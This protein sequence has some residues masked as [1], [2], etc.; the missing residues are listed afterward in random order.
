[1]LSLSGMSIDVRTRRNH[2]LFPKPTGGTPEADR[3]A[4]ML[5]SVWLGMRTRRGARIPICGAGGVET[6]EMLRVYLAGTGGLSV[7]QNL[8]DPMSAHRILAGALRSGGW[9]AGAYPIYTN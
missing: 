7:R 8:Y 4:T 1:M 5:P 6:G 9:N 3:F 2:V